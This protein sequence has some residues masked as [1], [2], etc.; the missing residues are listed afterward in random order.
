MHFFYNIQKGTLVTV[1]EESFVASMLDKNIGKE[2]F[3][4]IVTTK[5]LRFSEVERVVGTESIIFFYK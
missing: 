2:N 3:T 4:K 1:I 5:D